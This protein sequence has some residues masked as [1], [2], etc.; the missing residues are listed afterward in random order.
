MNEEILLY[1]NNYSI[2]AAKTFKIPQDES[3]RHIQIRPNEIAIITTKHIDEKNTL[4]KVHLFKQENP[5][6]VKENL[7]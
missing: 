2:T 7:K 5:M 1:S 3:I 4:T 6:F